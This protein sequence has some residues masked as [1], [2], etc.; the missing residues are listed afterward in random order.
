MRSVFGSLFLIAPLA[1][2]LCSSTVAQTAEN[3]ASTEPE[4]VAPLLPPQAVG[5]FIGEARRE[6]RGGGCV[7]T[8]RL[9]LSIVV[10]QSG[11]V[12]WTAH[13][14]NHLQCSEG[15]SVPPS[16]WYSGAGAL[17]TDARQHSRW[18]LELQISDRA[19]V[20]RPRIRVSGPNASTA[21]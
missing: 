19:R 11:G 13:S 14:Y 9:R 17:V 20:V 18:R 21:V 7:G 3:P 8:E 4:V 5:T 10:D 15:S 12:S 16:C 2:L 1:A 6:G